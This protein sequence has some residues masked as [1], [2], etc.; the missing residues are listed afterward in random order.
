LPL[1]GAQIGLTFAEEPL[2]IKITLATALT[3]AG[4]P[5]LIVG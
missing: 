4:I 3:V 5:L 1:F 2:T